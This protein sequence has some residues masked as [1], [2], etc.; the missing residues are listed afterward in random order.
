MQKGLLAQVMGLRRMDNILI[1]YDEIMS[2]SIMNEQDNDF[3]FNHIRY[4]HSWQQIIM[5]CI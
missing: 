2:W 1:F 3:P 5:Q 4:L